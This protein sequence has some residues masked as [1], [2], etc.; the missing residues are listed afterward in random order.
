MTKFWPIWRVGAFCLVISAVS[1]YWMGVQAAQNQYFRMGAGLEQSENH[2]VAV[3]LAEKLGHKAGDAKFQ[4]PLIALIEGNDNAATR[5][6]K[7]QNQQIDAVILSSAEIYVLKQAVL[8]TQKLANGTAAQT[9][10][11]KKMLAVPPLFGLRSLAALEFIPI[12]VIVNATAKHRVTRSE[13]LRGRRFLIVGRT[14]EEAQFLEQIFAPYRP[15]KGAVQSPLPQTPKIKNPVIGANGRETGTAEKSGDATKTAAG[16]QLDPSF[17]I[18]AE[19]LRS[20]QSLSRLAENEGGGLAGNLGAIMGSDKENSRKKMLDT[21]FADLAAEKWDAVILMGRDPIPELAAAAQKYPLNL[22]NFLQLPSKQN[23]LVTA[24]TATR[25]DKNIYN[26]IGEIESLAV[27]TQLCVLSRMKFTTATAV[28]QKLWA[29]DAAINQPIGNELKKPVALLPREKAR[30]GLVCTASSRRRTV[31]RRYTTI[32]ALGRNCFQVLF[33][34]GIF[35]L[36]I[37]LGKVAV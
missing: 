5:L 26:G 14:P 37:F 8:P 19:Q 4:T 30:I 17:G 13:D 27:T 29:R 2:D 7:L 23:A 16:E 25:I 35:C 3:A 24:V 31:L 34:S 18:S 28:M 21:A 22:L 32:R 12:H 10:E 1:I 36:P 33:C 15:I 11:A 6:G 20:I 9:K